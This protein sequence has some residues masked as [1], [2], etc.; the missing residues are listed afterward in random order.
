MWL[1][2]VGLKDERCDTIDYIDLLNGCI[3]NKWFQ[4]G[5]APGYRIREG[6]LRR[7]AGTVASKLKKPAGS[8][9]KK[10]LNPKT[11]SLSILASD[12]VNI[13]DVKEIEC[14]LHEAK[15]NKKEY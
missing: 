10:Y 5:R 3:P 9:K 6:R 2:V 4:I 7:E 1:K 8:S 15:N 13:G 11:F 14:E 12:M